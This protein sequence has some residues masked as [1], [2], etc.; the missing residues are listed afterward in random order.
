[1]APSRPHPDADRRR[2]RQSRA[3]R[4]PRAGARR[5]RPGPG[6]GHARR[7]SITRRERRRCRAHSGVTRSSRCHGPTATRSD[8][9]TWTAARRRRR[10]S[11]GDTDARAVHTP[12]HA[13]DHLCFWH[14]ATRTLFCGDLA[15]KGTT[16]WIPAQPGRRPGGLSRVARARPRPEPARLLP[17]HGPVIDDPAPRPARLHRPSARARRAGDCGAARRRPH[18]EAIVARVYR[19]LKAS[20]RAAGARERAWRTCSSWSSDGRARLH[21]RRVAYH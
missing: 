12:G 7:T 16:V 4:R 11:A 13:P 18:A 6:A 17:A 19:G 21:R 2:D 10:D 3:S 20:L 15:I 5:T 9:L 14:E 1:M 8:P